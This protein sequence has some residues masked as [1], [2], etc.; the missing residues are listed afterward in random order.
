LHILR[1]LV[2]FRKVIIEVLERET[3]IAPATFS[4]ATR[5]S[6]EI[7]IVIKWWF[8]ARTYA[9]CSMITMM[10]PKF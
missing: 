2:K 8:W 10:R 6:T 9:R 3:G 7:V 1:Q 4:L 5:R